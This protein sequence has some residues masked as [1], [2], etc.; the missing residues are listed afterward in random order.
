VG[1]TTGVKLDLAGTEHDLVI[2]AVA[3][4]GTPVS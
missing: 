1:R 4:T 2:G 3:G